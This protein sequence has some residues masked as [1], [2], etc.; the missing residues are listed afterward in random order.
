MNFDGFQPLIN[1]IEDELDAIMGH[2][3]DQVNG[4]RLLE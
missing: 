2:V 1:G 4:Q 3:N